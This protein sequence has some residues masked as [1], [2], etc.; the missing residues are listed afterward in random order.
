MNYYDNYGKVIISKG[1]FL[2][3][4]SDDKALTDLSDNLFLCLDNSFWSDE[5]KTMYKYKLK[6]N[7]ELILTIQNDFIN[8]NKSIYKHQYKQ[9]DKEL[10]TTIYNHLFNVNQ[11]SKCD[12]VI[13]KTNKSNFTNFCNKLNENNYNGLFNYIDGDKGQ[14]EIVIFNPTEYLTLI[15][16]INYKSVKLHKLKDCKRIM[17]NKKINYTYP[18]LYNYEECIKNCKYYPSI[19]YYIYKKTN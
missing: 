2:Y 14:F 17:L 5:N 8:K 9:E 6:K 18:H 15:E 13:L 4:W 11:Y 16:T 3:H 19:F 10:L 7:I 1:A 12:D